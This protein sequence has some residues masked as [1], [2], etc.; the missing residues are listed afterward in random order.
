MN[1]WV[2][3]VEEGHTICRL[4][5]SVSEKLLA[6]FCVCVF[7]RLCWKKYLDFRL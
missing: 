6:G 5:L 4:S 7:I 2:S 1:E 3:C